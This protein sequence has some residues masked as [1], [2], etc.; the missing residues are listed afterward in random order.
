M[1]PTP[2]LVRLLDDDA[3][4]R[5]EAI[6]SLDPRSLPARFALRHLVLADPDAQVRAAAVQR[7]GEVHARRMIPALLEAL[8]DSMP[9]VRDRA[10][11]ALARLGAEELLLAHAARALRKEPVWW[12]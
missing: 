1:P 10:F 3:D 8:T 12:V 11:R 7:L 5:L 6:V 9:S 4:L 2:A